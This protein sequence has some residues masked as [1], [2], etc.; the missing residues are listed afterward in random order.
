MIVYKVIDNETKY[1]SNASIFMR[2]N[3]ELEF[4]ELLHESK[5][6]REY[7]PLYYTGKTI[8]AVPGSVGI[9]CFWRY[10]D[11]VTFI[12]Y[13][14]FR[15]DKYLTIIKVEGIGYPTEP[16]NLWARC[17]AY[18]WYLTNPDRNSYESMEAPDGSVC[19]QK[20]RVLG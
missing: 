15:A 3:T 18:P 17:G 1:G 10:R 8:E 11:A 12:R 16:V 19:F 4:R 2:E 13:A 14:Y 20:V 9:L 6:L 7:F 5:A